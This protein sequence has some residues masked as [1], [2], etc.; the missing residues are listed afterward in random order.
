MD[1]RDLRLK[2]LRPVPRCDNSTG[3]LSPDTLSARLE[4][5]VD[6]VVRSIPNRAGWLRRVI[7]EAA[8]REFAVPPESPDRPKDQAA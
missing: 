2:N 6:L 5:D 3:P 8:R 7:T 1:S 4:V